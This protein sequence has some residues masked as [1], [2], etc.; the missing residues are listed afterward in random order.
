MKVLDIIKKAEDCFTGNGV[1]A[2]TIKDAEIA[3]NLAFSEEYRAYL[4]K[5]AV[6]VPLFQAFF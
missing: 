6:P 4:K 1:S 2:E 5:Y 3:L